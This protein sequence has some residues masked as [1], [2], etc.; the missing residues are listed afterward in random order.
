MVSAAVAALARACC[1]S[2]CHRTLF[3]QLPDARCTPP[4][5]GPAARSLP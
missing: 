1:A 3:S 5:A 2:R 4:F